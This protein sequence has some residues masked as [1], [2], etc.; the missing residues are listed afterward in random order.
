[1]SNTLAQGPITKVDTPDY[2]VTDV[3][4]Y[5]SVVCAARGRM[6]YLDNRS[7]D[8]RPTIMATARKGQVQ[9]VEAKTKENPIALRR[10]V[11]ARYQTMTAPSQN[12][13]YGAHRWLRSRA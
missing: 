3:T 9:Y 12:E 1:M 6:G 7:D 2:P 13:L 10:D 8:W 5:G 11:G 4:T